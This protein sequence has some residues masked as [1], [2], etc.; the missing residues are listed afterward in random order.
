MIFLEVFGMKFKRFFALALTL[1]FL[2]SSFVIFPTFNAAEG[3][4][5]QRKYTIPQTLKAPAIDGVMSDGE[6]TGAY[7]YFINY[8]EGAQWYGTWNGDFIEGIIQ[9][10]DNA[11]TGWD[12]YIQWVQGGDEATYGEG[13]GGL[14]FSVIGHDSTRFNA[15]VYGTPLNASVDAIQLAIDPLNTCLLYTS[16]C[17]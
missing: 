8:D 9:D 11:C 17:V 7:H 16:R 10:K 12:I 3:D 1:A 13:D 14:Y 2:A 4:F 6:W 15:P 5:Q